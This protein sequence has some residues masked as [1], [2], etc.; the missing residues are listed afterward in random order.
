[1][2]DSPT[3]ERRARGLRMYAR[4]FGLSEEQ[5]AA[6]MTEMLGPHMAEEA[7]Q[8]GAG[9]WSDTDLS[10]RDRSLIVIAALVTQGGVDAR[11]RGHLRWAP[12]NGVTRAELDALMA[13]LAVY[14]GYPRA[15]T[16]MELLRDE[17][18]PA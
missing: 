10:M 5:V 4:Q 2:S 15:S 9:A 7:W 11:L 14:V 6:H 1:M 17:L 13:L 3:D 8:S 16:G 12:E 18:G